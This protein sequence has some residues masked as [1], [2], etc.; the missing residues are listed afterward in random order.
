MNALLLRIWLIVA[1][2]TLI[3]VF[4]CE[5]NDNNPSGDAYDTADSQP[6][7]P[8]DT[9]TTFGSDDRDPKDSEI[10][11]DT[12]SE[13]AEETDTKTEAPPETDSDTQSVRDSD[14]ASDEEPDTETVSDTEDTP[15]TETEVDTGPD[16]DSESEPPVHCEED[17]IQTG[18]FC[19]RYEDRDSGVGA[20]SI[21]HTSEPSRVVFDT[22]QN[23]PFINA[24]V[25]DETVTS[26]RASFEIEDDTIRRCTEQTVEGI[27]LQEN[28]SVLLSGDFDDCAVGYR[29]VFQEV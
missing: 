25:G 26:N 10:E 9:E 4:G 6:G 2:W 3:G 20:L 5:E 7:E 22:V 19:I 29:V 14:S 13:T 15:A 17:A 28:G 16:S 23:V 24:G 12:T 21:T 1:L 11:S 8:T 27:S 18:A